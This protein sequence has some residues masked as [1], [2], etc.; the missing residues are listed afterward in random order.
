MVGLNFKAVIDHIKLGKKHKYIKNVFKPD[1]VLL[2]DYGGFNLRIAKYLRKN[3]IEV[4]YYITPQVWG[5][6][7]D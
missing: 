3:N 6:K 7:A 4:H 5:S 1:L 2:I